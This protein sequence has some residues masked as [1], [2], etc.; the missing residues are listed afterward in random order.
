VVS[1]MDSRIS[2]PE[3][4]KCTHEAEWTPFHAH[5]FSQNLVAPGI[6]PGPPDLKEI[7]TT[8]PQKYSITINKG[9]E[10]F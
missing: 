1:V 4:L 9:T 10:V 3:P 7:M 6:G 5:Y 2:R 8:R